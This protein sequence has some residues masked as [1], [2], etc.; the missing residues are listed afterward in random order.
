MTDEVILAL[1]GA[2]VGLVTANIT[3]WLNK[4]AFRE[5]IAESDILKA[6][7]ED[8]K[9]IWEI[10]TKVNFES[11]QLLSWLGRQTAQMQKEGIPNKQI[12]SN[13][14]KEFNPKS[15]DILKTVMS[16]NKYYVGI[17]APLIEA[18]KSYED[19]IWVVLKQQKFDKTKEILDK[20][21]EVFRS[22]REITARLVKREFKISD[23]V[24]GIPKGGYLPEYIK[25]A[26]KWSA[27]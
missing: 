16:L 5:E 20:S 27:T 4:R 11:I 8:Y 6:Q 19:S 17:S 25:E 7:L 9:S 23:S 3:S 1:I 26:F 12:L 15:I 13:L 22:I 24:G 2:S 18:L 21:E 10:V 14:N